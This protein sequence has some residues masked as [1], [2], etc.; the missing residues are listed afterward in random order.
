MEIP[1]RDD[2][3]MIDTNSMNPEIV[4]GKIVAVVLSGNTN[5]NTT[6]TDRVFYDIA[7]RLPGGFGVQIFERQVPQVRLWPV[8]MEL[9][10]ERM[11]GVSVIGFKYGAEIR[12]HFYEAPKI[13]SCIEPP[14]APTPGTT[15]VV[16]GTLIAP[17][18]GPGTGSGGE[19]TPTP[20]PGGEV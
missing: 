1:S 17:T 2:R 13:F 12:W 14:P 16:P 10:I 15:P 7:T 6:R 11:N 18:Q 19:P 5:D 20:A 4:V 8:D 9:D 3:I